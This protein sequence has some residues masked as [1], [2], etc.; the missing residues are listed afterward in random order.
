MLCEAG[1]RI[2]DVYFPTDSFVY[3]IAL[4]PGHQDLEITVIGAEGVVGA[5]VAAWGP[6]SPRCLPWCKARAG[7]GA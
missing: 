6:R 7:R 2:R 3:L 1:G 4:V 5:V